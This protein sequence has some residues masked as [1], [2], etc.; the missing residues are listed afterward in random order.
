MRK[1]RRFGSERKGKEECLG[2]QQLGIERKGRGGVKNVGK[3]VK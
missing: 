2:S 3:R 1:A